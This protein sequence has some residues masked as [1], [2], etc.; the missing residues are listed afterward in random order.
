MRPKGMGAC[1]LVK[2]EVM[3]GR[4]PVMVCYLLVPRLPPQLIMPRTLR[5]KILAIQKIYLHKRQMIVLGVL[6]IQL[7]YGCLKIPLVERHKKGEQT[8]AKVEH[9]QIELWTKSDPI[10]VHQLLFIWA[11][12]IFSN[13]DNAVLYSEATVC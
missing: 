9:V 10:V 11:F 4:L 1:K 13:F 3:L 8:V 6:L 2:N 5:R 12:F 7:T